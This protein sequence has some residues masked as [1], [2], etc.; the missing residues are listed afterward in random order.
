MNSKIERHSEII[1]R[2]KQRIDRIMPDKKETK[3]LF[4]LCLFMRFL[5]TFRVLL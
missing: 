3:K 2:M 5:R 4:C 1:F